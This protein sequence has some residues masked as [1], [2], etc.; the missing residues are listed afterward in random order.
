MV[1]D[2]HALSTRYMDPS[3]IKQDIFEVV[4]DYISGGIDPNEC[5][6]YV[7]SHVRK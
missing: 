2:W 5:T 6:F 7:Q 4:A 1:A 3:N